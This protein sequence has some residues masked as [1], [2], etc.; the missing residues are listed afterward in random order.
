MSL[1][2]VGKQVCS[3]LVRSLA[4]DPPGEWLHWQ[5][6]ESGKGA[7]ITGPLTAALAPHTPQPH[8]RFAVL[9]ESQ[10][11]LALG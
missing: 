6:G 9:V 7:S 11:A 8:A 10:L 2:V 5:S 4:K 1:A 3:L